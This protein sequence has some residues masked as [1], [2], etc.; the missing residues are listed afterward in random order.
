MTTE[1]VALWRR[2]LIGR[3]EFCFHTFDATAGPIHANAANGF[4][5]CFL[6][7]ENGAR[8]ELTSSD[9]LVEGGSSRHPA[10]GYA[11]LAVATG[12]TAAVYRIAAAGHSTADGPGWSGDGYD[13]STMPDPEG[14][15]REI[16][17]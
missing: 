16:S 8:L 17:A 9:R 11:H 13:D 10:P 12:S 3:R 5:S 2:D 1:H 4:R 6:R 7:L 15:L 14:N